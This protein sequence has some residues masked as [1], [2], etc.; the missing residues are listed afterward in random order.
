MSGQFMPQ[1]RNKKP[2]KAQIDPALIPFLDELAAMIA[3]K[4][5][6][7]HRARKERAS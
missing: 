6:A 5:L 3:A 2:K 1:P 4:L 7:E